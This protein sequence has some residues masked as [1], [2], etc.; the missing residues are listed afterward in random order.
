MLHM[1]WKFIK[2]TFQRNKRHVSWSF[3]HEV[4]AKTLKTAQNTNS[5]ARAHQEF[6]SWNP[7]HIVYLFFSILFSYT[8]RRAVP[9]INTPLLHSIQKTFDNWNAETPLFSCVLTNLESGFYPFALVMSFAGLQKWQL[10]PLPIG[11]PTP[12][13]V[14]SIDCRLCWL[15]PWECGWTNLDSGCRLMTVVGFEFYLPDCTS[16][17]CL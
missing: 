16:Y 11:A 5:H 1:V 7:F 15:V 8:S 13:E 9:S 3:Q 6:I 12:F 14:S 10:H 2:L 4:V 17:R